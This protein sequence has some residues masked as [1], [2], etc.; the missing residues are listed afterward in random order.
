VP[1]VNLE[2]GLGMAVVL[3]VVFLVATIVG[4]AR[5]DARLKLL[6]YVA[7]ALR[8]FGA[9]AYYEVDSLI[10][11]TG[12]YQLYYARGLEYAERWSHFDFAM[13]TN[14]N[15]WHAHQ[16]WGTQFMF[17]PTGAV[18]TLVG[19][20]MLTQFIVFALFSFVGLVGFGIAFHRSNPDISARRYLRWIWL[21]PALWFWPS[22]IGKEA[23]ILTGSGLTVLGYCGRRGRI[24][25]PVMALG[26]ALVFAIRPQVA[27]VFFV[28]LMLAQWAGNEQRWSFGRVVQGGLLV[29]IS[30]AGIWFAKQSLETDA[31]S[32]ESV[33]QY[34]E[35][36]AD[37]RNKGAGGI[38]TGEVAL[39]GVP[40]ALV[41]VWFRPF[42]WEAK[43]ATTLFSA[44]EITG[45]WGAAVVHRRRIVAN[46]KVW[47]RDR[48][49][50]LAIPFL[51]LYSISA[52]MTMWNLGIVAR[53]RT[54]LFPFFFLLLEVVPRCRKAAASAHL[55][56]GARPVT[57]GIGTA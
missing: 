41:N 26:L 47:R 38:K 36:R 37:V 29:A 5:L 44:L 32:G 50:R 43:S 46:L 14:S 27:M 1:T 54:L 8:L 7:L 17:F 3:A 53:Q 56:N 16:W 18:A 49:L 10:Y 33:T 9:V 55:R 31:P 34:M 21:F 45:L 12:D 13:F 39:R 28:S 51:A 6:I 11:T 30:V 25:W 52:G 2:E 19:S 24:Q 20:G 42:P 48:L 15:E 22:A 4:R 57:R 23:L 35:R 40:P